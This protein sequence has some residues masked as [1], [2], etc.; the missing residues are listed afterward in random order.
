MSHFAMGLLF[1]NKDVDVAL[2][3]PAVLWFMGFLGIKGSS[4]PLYFV[5]HRAFLSLILVGY[6]RAC[7]RK[8]I[9]GRS[10][11][12]DP[13]RACRTVTPIPPLNPRRRES[14]CWSHQSV[15]ILLLVVRLGEL[16]LVWRSDTVLD[17]NAL[18][19]RSLFKLVLLMVAPTQNTVIHHKPTGTLTNTRADTLKG[20]PTNTPTDTPTGIPRAN[21]TLT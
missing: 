11:D 18:R 1:K 17:C 8:P 3:D 6:A 19:Q 4:M 9:N 20:T 12:F 21:G 13:R 2:P 14:H 16:T 15:T 5:S 10:T 7:W